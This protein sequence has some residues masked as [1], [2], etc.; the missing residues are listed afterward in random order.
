MRKQEISAP[1]SAHQ[2]LAQVSLSVNNQLITG[3]SYPLSVDKD[4]KQTILYKITMPTNPNKA[5]C[6]IE[7]F[8]TE[9]CTIETQ[10]TSAMRENEGIIVSDD[11]KTFKIKT[12]T[13]Q[14]IAVTVNSDC[15]IQGD[16]YY[17]SKDEQTKI[18]NLP[19][20][21][22]SLNTAVED[23]KKCEGN[24]GKCRIFMWHNRNSK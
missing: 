24:G 2:P 12:K 13:D 17:G 6:Y 8:S 9:G 20:L 18:N 16:Y 7:E 10:S 1:S 19:V 21:L 22:F 3:L 23:A 11:K 14:S 15:S 5:F 4:S